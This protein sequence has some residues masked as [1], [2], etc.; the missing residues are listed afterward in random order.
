M[1][2]SRES[3]PAWHRRARALFVRRRWLFAGL[4]VLMC[5]I[6][7]RSW[8]YRSPAVSDDLQYFAEAHVPGEPLRAARNAERPG[9]INHSNLR[10]VLLRGIG[11][12]VW[13]FGRN[14]TG[15]YGAAIAMGLLCLLSLCLFAR[16]FSGAPSAIVT[17]LFA[18]V[19]Y[20]SIGVDTRLVPDN[21]GVGLALAGIALIGIAANK[22][23][24]QLPERFRDRAWVP[25]V[26]AGL[27]GLLL[28]SAFSAR[29]TFLAFLPAAALVAWLGGRWRLLLALLAGF[30]LGQLLEILYFAWA[31]GDPWIRWK[32]LLGY[33][34]RVAVS[35]FSHDYDLVELILRYPR[36]LWKHGAGDLLFF[37]VG[38]AGAILWCV[39]RRSA[40]LVKLVTLLC[41]YGVI[42][43]AIT[44][45]DPL[46]PF[47]RTKLRYYAAAAPL[48]YLA[49]A[50]L[51]CWVAAVR[52]SESERWKVYGRKTAAIAG[53]GVIAF[54]SLHAA[55]G[56][57]DF[58][59]NGAD[60]LFAA[61][62]QIR[63]DAGDRRDNRWIYTDI[64]TARSF[65]VLFRKSDGWTLGNRISANKF[66]EP[67]YLLLNWRR[68]NANVRRRYRHAKYTHLYYDTIDRYPLIFR[69]RH[70]SYFTDVF[71]VGPTAGSRSAR[72]ISDTLPGDW[73]VFR[74]SDRKADNPPT[75]A[76]LA[77]GTGEVYYSGTGKV[78]TEP[79]PAAL[80]AGHYVKVTFRAVASRPTGVKVEAVGWPEGARDRVRMYVGRVWADVEPRQYAVWTYIPRNLRSYRL[81]FGVWEKDRRAEVSEIRVE[82]LDLFPGENPKQAG[83]AW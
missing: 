61:A 19:A 76:P 52:T 40:D 67:G 26:V 31:M 21:L 37:V 54:A 79:G 62:G 45:I 42:A 60:G 44:R 33:R 41:A 69:H 4:A 75:R 29:A 1:T 15:Y 22:W 17:G 9:R 8:L 47:M 10:L 18:A 34:S 11:I 32:I 30:L 23:E 35:R 2:E 7:V 49:A 46:V 68:I 24:L 12:S 82:L 13:I 48:F 66:P 74:R 65:R 53:T 51:I 39:R 6:A 25:L 58:T 78:W 77:I 27:G 55:A 20:I 72:D 14:S 73:T 36:E 5:W 38:S 80:P 28:W 50:D 64:R 59:R 81:L 43:F 70:S 16:V 63:R 71:A 3:K 57:S 56:R 83:G